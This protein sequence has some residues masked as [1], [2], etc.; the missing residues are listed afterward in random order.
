MLE[1]FIMEVS[2]V[3]RIVGYHMSVSIGS[4][5]Y[6]FGIVIRVDSKRFTLIITPSAP[7]RVYCYPCMSIPYRFLAPRS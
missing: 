2:L 1:G 5:V 3:F 6:I 7:G 4:L